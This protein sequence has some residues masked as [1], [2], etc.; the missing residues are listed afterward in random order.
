VQENIKRLT[1]LGYRIIE[2][3]EGRLCTGRIG[4]GRLAS[5]EKIVG[6]IEEELN[7]KENK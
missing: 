1:K 3:E 6:V 4:K 7:K 2:P 5:V